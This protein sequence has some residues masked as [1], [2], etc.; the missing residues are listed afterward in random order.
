[1]LIFSDIFAWDGW[2]GPLRLVSGKC[3]LWIYDL[4]QASGSQPIPMK[5]ILLVAEDVPDSPMS[6]KSCAGHV[7]TL[8][9]EKFE[10]S[11]HRLRFIAYYPSSVYGAQ[12]EKVIPERIEE[13]ELEWLQEKAMQPKKWHAVDSQAQALVR[14]LVHQ[15]PGS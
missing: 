14:D 4:T 13:A 3:R 2:G 10:I 15:A 1:M 9:A 11:P 5:S 6:V 7:A 8:V 12:N